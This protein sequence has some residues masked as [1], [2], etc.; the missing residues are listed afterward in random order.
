MSTD[1]IEHRDTHVR[2]HVTL[3]MQRER[4]INTSHGDKQSMGVDVIDD[5]QLRLNSTS[6]TGAPSNRFQHNMEI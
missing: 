1:E 3:D 4:G 2:S 6:A 5:V